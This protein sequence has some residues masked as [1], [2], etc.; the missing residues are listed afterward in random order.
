M[1]QAASLVACVAGV[2]WEGEGE[3]AGEIWGTED[4]D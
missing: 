4:K 3:N 2:N 1:M